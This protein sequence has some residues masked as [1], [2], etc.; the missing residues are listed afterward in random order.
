MKQIHND[1]TIFAMLDWKITCK[2]EKKKYIYLWKY[3]YIIRK[4]YV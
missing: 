2:T 3:S 4:A 1:K